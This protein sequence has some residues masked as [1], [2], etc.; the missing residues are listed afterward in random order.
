MRK[1]LSSII[2]H[3]ILDSVERYSKDIGSLS[4]RS[5]LMDNNLGRAFS[6]IDDH[7]YARMED[8]HQI[9]EYILDVVNANLLRNS[10]LLLNNS[11][12]CIPDEWE[13][14]NNSEGLIHA[15]LD[16]TR[17]KYG[18]KS[19]KIAGNGDHTGTKRVTLSQFV[20]KRL[21][22]PEGFY[23]L[24]FFYIGNK[25]PIVQ[26]IAEIDFYDE[27]DVFLDKHVFD[28]VGG[29]SQGLTGT[30]ANMFDRW[31]EFF[32]LPEGAESL[33]VTVGVQ[34]QAGSPFEVWIDY[35][36]LNPGTNLA[37]PD[38]LVDGIL[39]THHISTEGLNAKVIKTGDI[40]I[41]NQLSLTTDSGDIRLYRDSVNNGNVLG[42]FNE[43]D[44][45]ILSIGKYGAGTNEFGFQI[46]H[47]NG[48]PTFEADST[49]RI[50]LRSHL[51]A[52]NL[53]TLSEK[54]SISDAENNIQV[55]MGKTSQGT[56]GIQAGQTFLSSEG[57]NI[58]EGEIN[59]GQNGEFSVDRNGNLTSR[60][61]RIANFKIE[62]NKLYSL[63]EALEM[64]SYNERF[65]VK[66]PLDVH[67]IMGQYEPNKYGIQAGD[68][69]L[70]KDGIDIRSGTI[71]LGQD[72]NGNPL[73]RV[74]RDGIVQAVSG[75]I[76]GFSLGENRL[77]SNDSRLEL[78]ASESQITLSD[79]PGQYATIF[80]PG[81]LF[82]KAPIA[83]LSY[84]ETKEEEG[85]TLFGMAGDIQGGVST[86]PED[87]DYVGVDVEK[88]YVGEAVYKEMVD[89]FYSKRTGEI[90]KRKGS[91]MPDKVTVDY[92]V[93]FYYGN[94]DDEVP[95][96][97]K[98]VSYT[99]EVE[100][101][102]IV[103][104]AAIITDDALLD[105]SFVRNL[106]VG[107]AEIRMASIGTAHID[108]IHG[109][110]IIAH[111]IEANHLTI[112]RGG[113]LI[114]NSTFSSE[115]FY[116][117]WLDL[118]PFSDVEYENN[119]IGKNIYAHQRNEQSKFDGASILLTESGEFGLEVGIGYTLKPNT[120]YTFSAFHKLEVPEGESL[121]GFYLNVSGEVLDVEPTGS[122]VSDNDHDTESHEYKRKAIRF[123][124]GG[125]GKVRLVSVLANIS[126]DAVKAYI[127]GFMLE[128]GYSESDFYKPGITRIHGSGIETGSITLEQ[129]NFRPIDE[130]KIIATINASEEEGLKI[131]S[132]RLQL[133]A[134]VD[135]N[136][137]NI[138]MNSNRIS[139]TV[140]VAKPREGVLFRLNGSLRSTT[141]EELELVV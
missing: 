83:R 51:G 82:A 118:I 119:L 84:G 130:T 18:D 49:G 132:N 96:E 61:G 74:N 114:P 45:R 103:R 115:E 76:G 42:F 97:P 66:S 141:G 22:E 10:A 39:K 86:V 71:E 47:E 88:V 15:C 121:D 104:N 50:Q 9:K 3:Q 73:F 57:I 4:R 117:D 131:E 111:S 41:T 33:K 31:Y 69:V 65:L 32:R 89:Y 110:K 92:T 120:F 135:I 24:S 67:V 95:E 81:G 1:E 129:L 29:L 122:L 138:E 109:R 59:L 53:D 90:I 72:I 128:E 13:A 123:R 100:F 46:G 34:V 126:S 99:R 63:N 56:Y 87:F 6:K 5:S 98:V 60:S 80:N 37:S 68:T 91:S 140:S 139:Q 106:I 23:T 133:T 26:Y 48:I 134:Q 78:N 38:S 136:T 27:N 25:N 17:H 125:N 127:D 113:N 36:L 55:V 43:S 85:V 54:I 93:S 79:D 35:P 77:F 94:E 11:N 105:A 102:V 28:N 101:R 44:K 75:R 7:E 20:D 137:S 19:F 70:N 62:P 30:P 12:V 112:G 116:K 21:I 40:V 64:D 16:D 8:V 52:I 58:G 107:S 14:Y 124:T 2:H 108:T